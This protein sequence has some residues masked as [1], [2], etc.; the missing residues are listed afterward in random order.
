MENLDLKIRSFLVEEGY[1][2]PQ[3]DTEIEKAMAE[4]AANPPEIPA[5]L[6]NP[7]LFLEGAKIKFGLESQG[8]IPVIEAMLKE[9]GGSSKYAWEAIGK[10]IGWCPLSACASYLSYILRRD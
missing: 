10:K 8:H 7:L 5:H 1:L 3:T 9:L 4:C 2:M 6:D